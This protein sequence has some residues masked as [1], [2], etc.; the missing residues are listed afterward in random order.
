MTSFARDEISLSCSGLEYPRKPESN[1]RLPGQRVDYGQ[2]ACISTGIFFVNV[3]SPG[4]S[5]GGV[6]FTV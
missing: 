6:P 5:T 4:A 3:L 2:L 1:R